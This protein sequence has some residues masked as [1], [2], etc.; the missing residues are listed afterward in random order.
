LLNSGLVQKRKLIINKLLITK[1][2]RCASDPFSRKFDNLSAL[3]NR[4]SIPELSP[5]KFFHLS[6][7]D[8]SNYLLRTPEDSFTSSLILRDLFITISPASPLN[9]DANGLFAVW[10]HVIPH[11]KVRLTVR[12][13]DTSSCSEPPSLSAIPSACFLATSLLRLRHPCALVRANVGLRVS[14]VPSCP[15]H[16]Y[17]CSKRTQW[18]HT[19]PRG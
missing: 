9:V 7:H 12:R 19:V 16:P 2:I 8:F 13:N 1:N 14:R 5:T 17:R 4:F 3:D 15:R 18:S 10:D 6:R 11:S